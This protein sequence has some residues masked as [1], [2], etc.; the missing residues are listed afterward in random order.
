MLTQCFVNK[1]YKRRSLKS[2]TVLKLN[3]DLDLETT[4]S[5]ANSSQFST[6]NSEGN[7][8][9]ILPIKPV[10]FVDKCHIIN[11]LDITL[12]DLICYY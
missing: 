10:R 4:C 6:L 3:P 1:K 2:A 11:Q 7:I 9:L 12:K 5:L 8:I